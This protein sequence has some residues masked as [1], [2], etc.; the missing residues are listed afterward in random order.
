[1]ILDHYLHQRWLQG[2][3]RTPGDSPP[4]P[5][6]APDSPTQP[7]LWDGEKPWRTAQTIERL[8]MIYVVQGATGHTNPFF[9][10]GNTGR[11]MSGEVLVP[12][13]ICR[14]LQNKI[15]LKMYLIL[16]Y[17]TIWVCADWPTDHQK[18][19]S[20]NPFIERQNKTQNTIFNKTQ[21]FPIFLGLT[22][23]L[24]LSWGPLF[25]IILAQWYFL[26]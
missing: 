15:V 9:C 21:I 10:K 8:S 5:A 23:C 7:Y 3:T 25:L 2:P 20:V 19:Y 4:P 26:S 17:V 22:P 14:F 13:W 11:G 24:Y 12:T 1:M 16:K 6:A 18:N